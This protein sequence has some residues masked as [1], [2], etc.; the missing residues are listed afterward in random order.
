MPTVDSLILAKRRTHPVTGNGKF[1]QNNGFSN[2]RMDAIFISA[3]RIWLA[4]RKRVMGSGKRGR[5]VEAVS[6]T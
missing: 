5:V 3:C 4:A 6:T 1:F 2:P